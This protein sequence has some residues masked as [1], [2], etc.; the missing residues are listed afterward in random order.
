MKD[1]RIGDLAFNR[2]DRSLWGI[3]HLNGICTLVR[4]PPPYTEWQRVVSWPYGDGRV[5]PRR[6]ARR[7]AVSASFGEISGKQDVRVLR[8]P[9]RWPAI[10][11]RSRSSTSATRCP[12]ASSSRPTAAIS[13][14]ART[15]PASRTSFAT[16][17]Q[18]EEARCGHQHRDRLLPADAARR[19][20]AARVPLY[21]RGIRA[22]AHRAAAAG[23]RQR[24]HVPRRTA[25]RG[26][27]GAEELDGRLA[28]QRSPSTTTDQRHGPTALSAAAARVDLSGGQG[29]KDAAAV[30]IPLQLLRSAAAQSGHVV[31]RVLAVRRRCRRDERL[32]L[33]ADYQRYDWRGRLS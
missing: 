21:R 23:G 19:R 12:M 29:Y 11:R 1:A 6:L 9:R 18:D 32:H 17:S 14:A 16:T 24:H 30:G 31:G 10:R 5:R 3:R 8:P 25:R 2:A 7:V 26:A 20:L 28:G 15:T 27:S 13:T 22:R 33:D 4:M